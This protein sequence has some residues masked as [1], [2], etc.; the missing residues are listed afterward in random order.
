MRH[1]AIFFFCTIVCACASRGERALQG[2]ASIG[3]AYELLS[4]RKDSSGW[5]TT[6]R[7]FVLQRDEYTSVKVGPTPLVIA[8]DSSG[9]RWQVLTGGPESNLATQEVSTSAKHIRANVDAIE[10]QMSGAIRAAQS[11]FNGGNPPLHLEVVLTPRVG[12]FK[13]RIHRVNDKGITIPVLWPHPVPLDDRFDS[14]WALE[15]FDTAVHEYYHALVALKLVP[16]P[17]NLVSEEAI[18]DL[19]GLCSTY[20]V[21][22]SETD[23]V[24]KADEG[25]ETEPTDVLKRMKGDPPILIARGVSR[26]QLRRVLGASRIE[27]GDQ[28]MVNRLLKFCRAAVYEAPDLT[29][30]YFTPI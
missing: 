1:L 15:Y 3:M 17:K 4:A 22:A 24:L 27:R 26:V 21:V 8:G 7:S 10:R 9:W 25:L 29:T 2:R 16:R 28:A 23:L 14:K 18:A 6:V 13:T 19:V 30:S 5:H 12:S 20:P 11:V